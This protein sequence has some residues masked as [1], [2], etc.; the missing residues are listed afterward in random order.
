MLGRMRRAR[1]IVSRELCFA[2]R[3]LQEG[4]AVRGVIPSN[5]AAPIR[6]VPWQLQIGQSLEEHHLYATSE[7][8]RRRERFVIDLGALLAQMDDS[9]VVTL[10]GDRVHDLEGLCSELE[11]GLGVGRIAR[12]IDGPEG[13]VDALRMRPLGVTR[14]AVK[15]RSIIW[16]EAHVLLREDAALF[17]RAVDA[18]TGVAAEHEFCS[19]DVL[20][21]QR[22]VF[23]GRPALEMYGE[24]PRGQFRAWY[25]E[26]GEAALWRVVTGR[27]T[28][29]LAPWRIG[30]EMDAV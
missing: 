14:A 4:R 29:N 21:I 11:R 26:D 18:I 17:G 9:H 15:R 19:D 3:T 23:V 6:T 24:D 10:D 20:L 1:Q 30:A 2:G 8:A 22:G 13:V 25:R 28:P 5:L 12:T 7:D 27:R 16:R